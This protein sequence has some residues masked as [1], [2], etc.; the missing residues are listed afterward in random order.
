MATETKTHGDYT[1]GW[2]CAL[3]KEQTAATAMLDKRHGNLPKLSHDS[4]TYTLGS[5]GQHN[6]VIACLP[7]GKYGTNSAA[8]VA[9][10]MIGTFPSIKVGLMVGIG[11]GIPPKVRLGDV[12]VSTPGGQFPGV[13]QWDMGK[14]EQGTLAKLETEHDLRGSKIPD[15]LDELKQKYPKAAKKHLKSD[16]LQ[17]V[18]FRADYGHVSAVSVG[19]DASHKEEE[20]ESCRFCDKTKIVERESQDM[21]VH[22]GLIASGNQVIKDVTFRDKLNK[23]LGSNVLCVEMEAAGMMNNFPCLVIRGICD[24][25][26]SHKNKAWQE[27]AAAV[28]AA[29]AK[30]LL[31]Y[32]QSS[33]VEGERLVKDVLKEVKQDLQRVYKKVEDGFSILLGENEIKK[34]KDTLNWLSQIDFAPQQN[35]YVTKC[36]SGTGQWLLDSNQFQAWLNQRKQTLFCP[37]IPGAGK[38]MI[39]SII[40]EHLQTKFRNDPSIG[41]A[42][43]YCNFRQQQEPADLLASLLKQLIQRQPSVPE[44]VR[45]LYERHNAQGTRPLF[46]EI[47]EGLHSIINDYSRAFI[48]ID[49]LDEYQVSND[50]S[51]LLS[52]IFKLQTK[53]GAGFF[54]T[55]RFILEITK[56]FEG[57]IS[58][59]IHASVDDVQKYLDGKM[60]RLWPFVSKNAALQEEVKTEITK[61]VDGM[62]LLAQLYLDSLV[63][64]TTTKAIRLALKNFRKGSGASNDEKKSKAL[65]DAYTQAMERIKGQEAGLQELAEQV[66]SWITCAKRPLTTLELQHALAVEISESELDEENLSEIEDMVSVCAG[67]VTVDE[68]SN[69]IRLIHYTTQEYFERTQVS[70]FPNAQNDITATCVT[71]LSFDAFQSGFC[72]T[73]KEFEERLRLNPLYDYAARNWG[74]H[75]RAASEKEEQLILGLLGS[76]AKVSGS[77]QAM[78]VSRT[79]SDYSQDVPRQ[80]TGVHLAAYFGLREEMTALLKNRYDPDSKDGGG[81]TPLWCAAA[82]GHEAVVKLLLDSGKVDVDVKDEDC[83]RTPLWCA[84]ARGHEAV[85]KLLLDSGKVDVDVKNERKGRTPLWYAAAHGHEAVVKLLLDSGKVDVDVKDERNGRTPLSYA[86]ERGHEAVVKLLLDSGKVDV[87]VKDERNGRTPL[88]WAAAHGHEAVVK[89]LLDSGKVDVDVKDED[90]GLTP[91]WWAAARGHEAVV[92]L[93]LDSGK[94]DVDVKD[95][96]GWTPLSYAAA[97]GHEAV[98]KL[99]T[100]IT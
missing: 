36:E 98:V 41:I 92:K 85:V 69:I 45:S 97:Q 32:V 62:F 6:V 15:Y 25:C 73:D 60:S 38:T 50:R 91:L 22:Y 57:S 49:A 59:K 76:E 30:E 87:D 46:G 28:A 8:N 43:L 54:A 89:L 17:D 18:L 9:T 96:D 48:I 93:L 42:Y 83:G 31:G 34:Q 100:S 26:D 7:K 24:Y 90:Y 74:I 88:W 77:S 13:V 33:D 67:L 40:I 51:M 52:E 2:I 5:I 11:G 79:Y 71:Y 80:M 47:V 84:A 16:S 65:N 99:L 72:L 44:Y 68:K 12:V 19:D 23:D 78:M 10:L 55:S 21:C 53:T 56:E 75:A 39:T 1:V 64:K 35:D 61:A 94:V 29:F 4:N 86:A 81:R 82:H 27:H 63:D 3:P 95:K 14:A 70:W 37:G 58:I 20:E 66:L